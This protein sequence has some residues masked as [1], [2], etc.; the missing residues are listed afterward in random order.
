MKH[1][2]SFPINWLKIKSSIWIIIVSTSCCTFEKISHE[3]PSK[4]FIRQINLSYPVFIMTIT[5]QKFYK[6]TLNEEAP[7]MLKLHT[8][9]VI[10]HN[11]FLS[12]RNVKINLCLSVLTDLQKYL[13]K[14]ISNRDKKYYS[15]MIILWYTNLIDQG[16]K[17]DKKKHA[18]SFVIG[19]LFF[20]FLL[21]F[22]SDKNPMYTFKF[23]LQF[24]VSK[25]F[26]NWQF[27]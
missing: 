16:I 8:L 13:Q 9:W 14:C 20:V 7:A 3:K 12:K 24:T 17:K 21:S 19:N 27:F 18:T 26:D 23:F 25:N 22:F 6:N 10:K 15:T 5:V 11:I 2:A 1:R 4:L